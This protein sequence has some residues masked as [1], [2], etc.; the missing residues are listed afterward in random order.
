MAKRAN[1]RRVKIHHTCSVG[2][3]AEILDLHEHT[4]RRWIR[5]EGLPVIGGHRPTLIRGKDL[6]AFLEQRR[7]RKRIKCGPGQMLCFRCKEARAP[8]GG[9]LDYFPQN[10]DAGRLQA[11]CSVC[12]SLMNR[13][14]RKD[15]IGRNFPKCTVSIQKCPSTLSGNV[16]RLLNVDSG[17]LVR[18]RDSDAAN[19]YKFPGK[20]SA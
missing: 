20:R 1:P 19:F 5:Y 17:T 10:A 9:M 4:I 15:N 7:E 11:L 8:A 12:E 16:E 2:E 3:W 18:R 6:R 14:I 13:V